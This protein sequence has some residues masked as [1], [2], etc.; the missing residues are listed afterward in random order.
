MP[1]NAIC[2]IM[3]GICLAAV[4]YAAWLHAEL[5]DLERELEAAKREALFW[6]DSAGN[7]RKAAKLN[8]ETGRGLEASARACLAREAEASR[9]LAEALE[10]AS[11]QAVPQREPEKN[12]EARDALVDALNL[13]L[14]PADGGLRQ[15]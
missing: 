9:R 6:E 7:W 14:A 3:G 11:P 2:T 4:C 15:E 12:S 10:S 5:T 1:V 13:P 8:E